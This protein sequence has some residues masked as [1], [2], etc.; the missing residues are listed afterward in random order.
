MKSTV[1]RLKKFINQAVPVPEVIL[2]NM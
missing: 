1:F 2:T